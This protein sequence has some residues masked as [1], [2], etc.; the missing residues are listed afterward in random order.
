MWAGS[1]RLFRTDDNGRHWKAVSGSFDGTPISAIEIARA[2]PK[3][4]F[5]GT[6]G[7]GIFRSRDGGVTWSQNLSGI[8]I[9]ARAITSITTHPKA[10]AAVVVTVASTGIL[11]S[12]VQLC[13]GKDL[14]YNHVFRSQDGGD[15]WTDIDAGK[16]PNVVFY[17]AAYGTRP[18]YQLFVGG[19]VGV[20]AEMGNGWLNISGNLPS[21]VVSDLVYH[22]K[23]STLTAATYGRGV[24]RIRPGTLQM[25]PSAYGSLPPERIELAV[26]LRVD[27]GVAA[28]VQLTP[29]DGASIG[30]Y[31]R[32]TQFTVQPVPGALGYQVEFAS[33]D[34]SV[35]ASST[36]PQIAFD[37]PGV[38]NYT[39][40]VWAILPDGLRSAA[41]AW[42]KIAYLK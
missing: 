24:W 41:S 21:V 35:G 17:A 23:D 10:P 37:A 7:G 20:W 15:T 8:D 29:E 4:L 25:L 2:R 14:P 42:R 3:L 39:W 32:T 22:H 34:L 27:P 5:V 12:G 16:L 1:N 31:P 33:K 40:R 28:P 9:P 19:D 38:G 6:T 13:T 18:P 30:V 36:T 11:G 26:G